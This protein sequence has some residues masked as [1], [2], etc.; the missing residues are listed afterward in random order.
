MRKIF[1]HWRLEPVSSLNPIL[2][3]CISDN[4]SFTL[5]SLQT[6]TDTYANSVDP[7]ETA[8]YES[9]HLDLHCLLFCF[10]LWLFSQFE[11][12]DVSEFKD[13]RLGKHRD[14]RIKM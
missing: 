10:I 4:K 13:R 11:I 12:M 1:S 3:D 9:S 5:S 14:E 7:D 6:I 2:N 8:R